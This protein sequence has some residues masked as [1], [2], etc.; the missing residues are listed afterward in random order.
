M[1]VYEADLHIYSMKSKWDCNE[2]QCRFACPVKGEIT[3]ELGLRLILRRDATSS[4]ESRKQDL[5]GAPQ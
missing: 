2:V 5:Y 4:K 1:L 3:I